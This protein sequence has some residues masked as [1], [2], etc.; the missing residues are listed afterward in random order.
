MAIWLR[1]RL[2]AA[3]RRADIILVECWG[4]VDDRESL[5]FLEAFC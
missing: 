4:A 5:W 1:V 2:V 3:G